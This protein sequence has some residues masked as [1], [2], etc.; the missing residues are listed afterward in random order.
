MLSYTLIVLSS[1]LNNNSAT[2]ALAQDLINKKN[3]ISIIFFLFDGAYTANAFIDMPTDEP[4]ISQQWS[5]FAQ[6]YQIRMVV[7][8][9][10]AARRGICSTN[11]AQGFNLGSIGE[12]IE[13]C[14]NADR[15]V[16][17]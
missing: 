5:D 8:S 12:L 7:C 2:L 16:S 17:L 14:D 15:V 3:K 11:L 10:S 13:N 9:A 6:K 1:H 4:N